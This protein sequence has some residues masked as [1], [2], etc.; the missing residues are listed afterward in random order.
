VGINVV[1]IVVINVDSCFSLWPNPPKLEQDF[2]VEIIVVFIVGLN[3]GFIVAPDG[4][5][6]G[7]H[8]VTRP[9]TSIADAPRGNGSV[10]VIATIVVQW[11]SMWDSM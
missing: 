10:T 11:E 3:V 5:H 6:C 1:I 4:N 8:G 9:I 2:T 7:A